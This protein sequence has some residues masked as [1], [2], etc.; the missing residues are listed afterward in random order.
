[1]KKMIRG[2]SMGKLMDSK[3]FKGMVSG[4]GKNKNNGK[5]KTE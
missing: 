4:I 5:T 3:I 1:M 2:K